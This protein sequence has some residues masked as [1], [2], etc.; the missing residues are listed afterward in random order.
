MYA[1]PMESQEALVYTPP[2]AGCSLDTQ[3]GRSDAKE[4][5]AVLETWPFWRIS[6]KGK[7]RKHL[8]VQTMLLVRLENASDFIHREEESTQSL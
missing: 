2:P 4:E 5:A 6:R 7:I 3:R 8:S 1:Q